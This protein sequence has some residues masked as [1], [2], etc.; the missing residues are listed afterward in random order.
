MRP[1]RMDW[2]SG[3]CAPCPVCGAATSGMHE[4]AAAPSPA[5]N[6]RDVGGPVVFLVRADPCNCD[7]TELV[8]VLQHDVILAEHELT[9][10]QSPGPHTLAAGHRW[11]P[12]A[13]SEARARL[14][15][16]VTDAVLSRCLD[17]G[18]V[19]EVTL[20]RR[21]P[22]TLERSFLPQ[23]DPPARPP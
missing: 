8:A 7:V 17:C 15:D 6:R 14:T 11:G 10:P 5:G 16:G 19:G 21:T 1:E 20:L 12:G 23:L 3:V 18:V 9:H 2:P 4:T 22:A 13:L